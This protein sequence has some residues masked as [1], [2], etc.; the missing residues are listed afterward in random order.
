MLSAA[1]VS[2]RPR[3]VFS[4]AVPLVEGP[5]WVRVHLRFLNDLNDERQRVGRARGDRD[6]HSERNDR[7]SEREPERNQFKL[8]AIKACGNAVADRG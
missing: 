5:G 8:L 3:V 7:H 1:S 2:E 6:L 4:E